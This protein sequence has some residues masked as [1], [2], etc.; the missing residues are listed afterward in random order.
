MFCVEPNSPP[1]LVVVPNADVP[2]PAA[3]PKAVSV[4]E[5]FYTTL[6]TKN[7][8]GIFGV[9]GVQQSISMK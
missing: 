3:V 8:G 6:K 5:T 1:V 9:H 7:T 4:D 2:K